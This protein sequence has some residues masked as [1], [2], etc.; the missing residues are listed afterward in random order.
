MPP[1]GGDQAVKGGRKAMKK[2]IGLNLQN[3]GRWMTEGEPQGNPVWGLHLGL[4]RARH[5]GVA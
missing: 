4:L 1:L 3:A 5:G 2:N